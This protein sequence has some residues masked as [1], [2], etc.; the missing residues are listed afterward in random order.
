MAFNVQ[1]VDS[2]FR[3]KRTRLEPGAVEAPNVEAPKDE[4]AVSRIAG[5]ANE[6]IGPLPTSDASLEGREI[7]R[8]TKDGVSKDLINQF[9]T[10]GMD[11]QCLE[12]VKKE[13]DDPNINMNYLI[14]LRNAIA[15]ILA[16][17]SNSQRDKVEKLNRLKIEFQTLTKQQADSQRSGG[18]NGLIFAIGGLFLSTMG[19]S[20]R[21]IS[22]TVD[23]N[24][25]GFLGRDLLPGVRDLVGARINA[26]TEQLRATGQF[27]SGEWSAESNKPT[28]PKE[29]FVNLFEKV[30]QGQ[31][32]AAQAG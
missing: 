20:E 3:A 5:I 2:L 4:A 1:E 11:S 23:R 14:R 10:M 9:E 17:L 13:L 12:T 32:R 22:N 26:T 24:F 16:S 7:N 28:D 15:L 31:Q 8:I 18:W 19:S 6:Q 27:A 25:V 21:F 30:L 29:Q